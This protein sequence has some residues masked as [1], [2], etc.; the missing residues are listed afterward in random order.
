MKIIVLDTG[1]L[2][3]VTNPKSSREADAAKE[4]LDQ[5]LAKGHTI[6]VPEIADYE[7]RRELLRA[8]KTAGLS[9]LDALVATT[10][11]LPLTTSAMRKAAELWAEARNVGKPTA[12]NKALDGDVILAAQVLIAFGRE[13]IVATTNG[14]HLSR[15]ARADVWSNIV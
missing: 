1:P 9:R 4:W 13:A 12:S 14:E 3:Y 5:A 7:L 11:Y 10:R 8:K 15:F 6:V 2:G